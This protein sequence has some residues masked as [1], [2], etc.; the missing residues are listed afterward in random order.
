MNDPPRVTLTT[1]S[2]K[3]TAHLG[4]M[5]GRRL[6]TATAIL[7][8]G[9]LGCGKTCFVQG[10]ARGLD[11][12]EDFTVTSPT[13]ALMHDYPGRLPL[14]HVD[15]YRIHGESDAESIGL[16]EAMDGDI[17]TAVE[18]AD[19]L[20]DADWPRPA[21]HIHFSMGTDDSRDVTLIACGLQMA[22]L[23]MEIGAL[24]NSVAE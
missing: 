6:L 1:N 11:V 4:F 17:V 5:I 10:L 8:S 13:Y 14:V 12:P 24:W 22:D 9:D 23:I 2:A 3:E 19:R 15:L 16:W 21:V 18:W 7:L 20:A